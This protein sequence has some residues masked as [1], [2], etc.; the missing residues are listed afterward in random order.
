MAKRAPDWIVP[1]PDQTDGFQRARYWSND[2]WQIWNDLIKINYEHPSEA[3]RAEIW[4]YM[5]DYTLFWANYANE[6][7]G[8]VRFDNLHSSDPDFVQALTT[9]LHSEYPNVGVIAE[10]FTDETTLLH[11]GPKWR[12]NLNLATP[13]DF[14]FVPQLREYLKYIHRVSRHVRYFMPV[15][16]HDSGSPAQEFGSVESTIPRYVAAALLG[17]GATGII[18]GVEY[19][20]MKK[21]NFIGRKPKMQFPAEPRFAKF[22]SRINTILADYPAFRHGDNCQ[23]MDDGHP[24]IIAAFR[25]DTGMEVKGFL[26]VCN[27]DITKSQRITIDL[28]PILGT[29]GPYP[30]YD[31]ISSQPHLIQQP[32]FELV[33]PPCSAR[34]LKI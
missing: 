7:G 6:T 2:G 16:S 31:L 1:D 22:I 30:C 20:E 17:T 18:Q 19:G 25:R 8:F 9:A 10:Y 24:A 13:W 28:T 34:V 23:F 29:E 11:T 14:K 4:S 26:V 15:T 5:I 27:F 33:L 32:N 21:I 3:I 12:L